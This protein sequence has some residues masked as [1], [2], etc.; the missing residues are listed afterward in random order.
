MNIATWV[1]RNGRRLPD[2][3][4]VA[5]GAQATATWAEFAGQVSAVAGGLQGRFGL[6]PGTGWPSS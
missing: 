2:R 6:R 4:A 5:V 3:P 1:Q